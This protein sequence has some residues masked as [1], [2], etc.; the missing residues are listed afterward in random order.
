M[1]IAVGAV[2]GLEYLHDKASPPV[3]YRDLR[4]ANILLGEG[5]HPKLSNFGLAKLGPVGDNTHVSTRVMGTYRY[6]LLEI[7]SGRKALDTSRNFNEQ[8]L[9]QWVSPLFKDKRKFS[10]V[11]DRPLQGQYPTRGLYQ[12]LAIASMYVQDQPTMRSMIADVVTVLTYLSSQKYEPELNQPQKNKREKDG[13]GRRR[14]EH[15]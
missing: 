4:S 1:K 7:I 15:K 12:A 11:A 13:D 2:K 5:Y 8:Y 10:Q 14:G 3:I 6:F 9:V